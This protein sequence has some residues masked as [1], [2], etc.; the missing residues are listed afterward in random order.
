MPSQNRFDN[1]KM[2]GVENRQNS[3][4]SYRNQ[5][6]QFMINQTQNPNSYNGYN[7]YNFN[8]PPKPKR[9]Y[10]KK[11][12][13]I[14]LNIFSAFLLV[15]SGFLSYQL[16]SF[17]NQSSS[18]VMGEADENKED[19]SAVSTVEIPKP[20]SISLNSVFFGD[21][22]WGRRMH[23]W[24]QNSQLKEAFPFS[25]LSTFDR[26]K[27][28]AWIANL[29]CPITTEELTNYQQETLLKFNCKPEY[30]EYAS[31]YF[32]AF[33]LAN[34]HTNNMEEFDGLTRTRQNLEKYGIQYFGHFDNSKTED[35]CEVVNLP[36]TAIYNSSDL[37][38]VN[39]LRREKGLAEKTLESS[40]DNNND[41]ETTEEIKPLEV[42][43]TSQA[44]TGLNLEVNNQFNNTP[45]PPIQNLSL[46]SN[47]S[48]SEEGLQETQREQAEQ[49]KSSPE[50]SQ[51]KT[52]VENQKI[53]ESEK[54]EGE[55]TFSNPES[56]VADYQIPV[57]MCGYHNVFR[58]PTEEE[59][60][61]IAKYSQHFITIV[62]PHQGAEYTTS[63]DALQRQY[64]R[65]MI[66]LG[67][68]FVIGGHTHS[69]NE[70]ES[71]NGKLIA[72]SLGNFIFD[73]QF[74]REV[75]TS[76]GINLNFDFEY[77]QKIAEMQSLI[78][79]CK[80]SDKDCLEIAKE[81]NLQ[82]PNFTV[83]YNLIGSQNRNQVTTKADQETLDFILQRTNWN[84]VKEQLQTEFN[85]DVKHNTAE[86][87]GQ[88][89][90]E[91]FLEKDKQEGS[92]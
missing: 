35:I 33:S 59:L 87:L 12:L 55:Y 67:A 47:S 36:S 77:S 40:S 69:M 86:V 56:F 73:Q 23:T 31:K 88:E 57:A 75:T 61:E 71:Y 63:S 25:G 13:I 7:G 84:N 46:Q 28:D 24:S 58:L 54:K 4:F 16:F 85:F 39:Q 44:S 17:N 6:N 10:N 42:T 76:Y 20:E 34:N 89:G 53:E 9:G 74:S 90:I 82:K 66:D 83:E 1:F 38:K 8:Q 21:V 70:T 11:N 64:F 15:I 80:I 26:E 60:Q 19:T 37:T 27:Y 43:Q 62:M 65:K 50:E 68:D 92:N 48:E 5:P 2:P 3:N 81:R 91:K 41:S 78:K 29:E 72:Y 32:N 45:N 52:E 30:L 14:G 22:F 79:E 51:E 49:E 18:R